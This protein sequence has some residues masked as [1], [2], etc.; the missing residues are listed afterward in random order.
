MLWIQNRLQV[1]AVTP[2]VAVAAVVAAAAQIF[3]AAASGLEQCLET[4]RDI[5]AIELC[6]NYRVVV[7]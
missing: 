6:E 7:T 4:L 2:V 1:V 5:A 3:N